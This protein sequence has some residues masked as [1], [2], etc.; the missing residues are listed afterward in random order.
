MATAKKPASKT[1]AKTT[2]IK[3][4]SSAEL[5]VKAAELR[6]ETIVLKR[7]TRVGDVQNVRAYIVKRRELARVLTAQN[8]LKAA[9]G[10]E[11]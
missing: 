4:L 7:G 9:E 11:K 3:T 2:D 1:P 5:A 10:K 6:E 8:A